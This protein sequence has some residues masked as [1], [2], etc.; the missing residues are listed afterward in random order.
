MKYFV[1][2]SSDKGEERTVTVEATSEKDAA[3]IVKNDM[4]LR[5]IKVSDSKVGDHIDNIA[6][7]RKSIFL[8]VIPVIAVIGAII[9]YQ[10]Y[11]S[12]Q[13]ILQ[14]ENIVTP[15]YDSKSDPLPDGTDS[16]YAPKKEIIDPDNLTTDVDMAAYALAITDVNDDAMKI[17][18]SIW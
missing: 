5:P 10:Y 4:Q 13:E 17:N 7:D 15:T 1:S 11:F 14:S 18:D 3:S 12:T 8:L 6:K 2:A 9:L 16:N